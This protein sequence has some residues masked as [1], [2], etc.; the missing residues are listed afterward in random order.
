MLG[1]SDEGGNARGLFPVYFLG[2]GDRNSAGDFAFTLLFF[3]D[4]ESFGVACVPVICV[5]DSTEKSSSSS[6]CC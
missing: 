3:E 5:G 4:A 6:S 2:E 1:P